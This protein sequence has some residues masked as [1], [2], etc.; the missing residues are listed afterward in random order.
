M[1]GTV[2]T[3]GTG[4][5]LVV[6]T[7]HD[8]QVSGLADRQV[9][10]LGWGEVERSSGGKVADWIWDLVRVLDLWGVP[11]ETASWIQGAGVRWAVGQVLRESGSAG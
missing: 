7:W 9:V 2:G 8:T 10:K 6:C 5:G 1:L 3:K 11:E 4:E